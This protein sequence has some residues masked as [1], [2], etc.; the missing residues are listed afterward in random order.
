MVFAAEQIGKSAA[1]GIYSI[2]GTDGKITQSA[3]VTA[4][5]QLSLCLSFSL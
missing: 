2:L 5:Q 1:G 3:E 4:V